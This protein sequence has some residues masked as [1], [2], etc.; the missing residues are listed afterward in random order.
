MGDLDLARLEARLMARMA[1]VLRDEIAAMSA[2]IGAEAPPLAPRPLAPDEWRAMP[3]W[4]PPPELIDPKDGKTWITAKDLQGL[5]QMTRET[6]VYRR[7]D[8]RR[9]SV[10]V[11]GKV[12]MNKPRAMAPAGTLPG[13][14]REKSAE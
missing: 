12:L 1:A 3:D 9:V 13:E 4:P 2:R 6:S 7:A 5:W 14:K 11:D 10:R 8:R